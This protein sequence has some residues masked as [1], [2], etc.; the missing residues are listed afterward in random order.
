LHSFFKLDKNELRIRRPVRQVRD[1]ER[2][3]EQ[4]VAP[5]DDRHPPAGAQ[6]VRASPGIV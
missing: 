5:I 3:S 6:F 4:R 2:A 1:D